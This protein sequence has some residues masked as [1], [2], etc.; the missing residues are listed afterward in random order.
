MSSFN[1]MGKR[2]GKHAGTYSMGSALGVVIGLFSVGIVTRFLPPSQYGL[3]ALYM[4]LAALLTM[5]YG[6]IVFKGSLRTV[7]GGDD[8]DEGDEG[9]EAGEEEAQIA[10][11]QARRALGTALALTALV[12]VAGT[13]IL[14]LVPQAASALLGQ[15]PQPEDLIIFA[16]AAGGLGAVWRLTSTVLRRE[17]RS[18]LFVMVQTSRPL[19]TLTATIP[20][21]LEMGL[22][23]AV[24]GLLVGN[25]FALIFS[26]VTIRHSWTPALD[27]A[28]IKMIAQ[29]GSPYLPLVLSFWAIQ[30]GN[31]FLLAQFAPP[32][33]VGVFRVAS[34]VAAFGGFIVVAFLRASGPLSREPI[35]KAAR[36]ERGAQAVDT[37]MCTYFALGTI[38]VMLVFVLAA[39]VLVRIAPPAYASAAPLI[40]WLVLAA[41][42]SGWFRVVYRY[43]RFPDKR[44]A[45]IRM[46]VVAGV[47][48][49][50]AGV[51]LVPPFGAYGIAW[52]TTAAFALA[53]LGLHL[54]AMRKGTTMTLAHRRVAAGLVLAA[55]CYGVARLL[56]DFVGVPSAVTALLTLLVYPAALVGT[57]IIPRLHVGPLA[58]IGRAAL[59]LPERSST[60]ELDKLE[61]RQRRV[62]RMV[63]RDGRTLEDVALKL[64]TSD[65]DVET[66]F[67]AGLRRLG[68]LGK[69]SKMD[70]EVAPYLLSTAA[71]ADR[72]AMWK[73]LAS[74]GADPA[75]TDTMATT[76]KQLRR[77]PRDAWKQNG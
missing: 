11:G 74:D 65:E 38:F 40:P 39:D 26:L 10:E 20:L 14:A 50:G 12:A 70:T 45:K 62:L 67:M 34:Q 4:G 48:F 8:D 5:V 2:L 7:F 18:T 17:R 6:L 31:I 28:M 21:V 68:G 56:E 53:A 60:L 35:H 46:A 76:L 72:D 66:T 47:I 52:A 49:F 54:V 27:P 3:Y 13:A 22:R 19:I 29:R 41:V 1:T 43:S 71:I 9:D 30:E 73:R 24:L 15:G 57:T 36:R 61:K 33:E 63:V 37:L 32:A 23:G 42:A 44:P 64:R 25:A 51:V 75:E 69:P 16:A 77:T 58:S 59:P 55:L